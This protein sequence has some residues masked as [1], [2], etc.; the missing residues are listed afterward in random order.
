MTGDAGLLAGRPRPTG[1][2][3]ERSGRVLRLDLKA[4]E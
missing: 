1:T 3:G 4:V 2:R